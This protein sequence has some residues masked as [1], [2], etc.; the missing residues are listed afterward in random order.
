MDVLELIMADHHEQ[1]RMFALL[2]DAGNNPAV[3]APIWRRLCVLL[4]VHAAA[5]ERL[6][7]PRLLDVGRG[8]AGDDPQEETTDAIG[9]HN[10][11]RDALD[12][13][14]EQGIGSPEWSQSVA[15]ARGANSDHMAEE[16]RGPLADFRRHA[17]LRERHDLGVAFAAFEAGH[18]DGIDGKDRDPEAYVR[19]ARAE[20]PA[21][22]AGRRTLPVPCGIFVCL[23]ATIA[24]TQQV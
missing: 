11:I 16:A 20:R 5:K 3:L 10:D 22:G 18:E 21:T 19:R 15:E 8:M 23:S 17:E 4:E 12:R 9:D 6:F 7:Y 14:R 24:G 1:R 2:D 13:A